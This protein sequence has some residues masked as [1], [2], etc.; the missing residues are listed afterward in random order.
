M[1]PFPLPLFLPPQAERQLAIRKEVWTQAKEIGSCLKEWMALPFAEIHL[2]LINALAL[3]WTSA[4][5]DLN[6]R[7]PEDEIVSNLQS[8][9]HSF[10]D[11][12]R[13]LLPITDPT[14]TASHWRVLFAAL[15]ALLLR[16]NH[17]TSHFVAGRSASHPAPNLSRCLLQDTNSTRRSN[18]VCGI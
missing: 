16:M 10:L 6:A 2:K 12:S 13:I 9:V 5:A 14:I 3:E 8:R 17:R 11:L 4:L 7:F 1:F 15:G 18:S